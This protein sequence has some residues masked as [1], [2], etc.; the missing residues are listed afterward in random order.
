MSGCQLYDSE[1]FQYRG[2]VL[3]PEE[4]DE[5]AVESLPGPD[6]RASAGAISRGSRTIANS[7]A[8]KPV[9]QAV[10]QDIGLSMERNEDDKEDQDSDAISEPMN[11]LDLRVTVAHLRPLSLPRFR[12]TRCQ[13][14]SVSREKS[15]T[16][17]LITVRPLMGAR[18]WDSRTN[19]RKMCFGN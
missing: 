4:H 9:A 14:S 10:D 7:I 5:A 19:G 8:V 2:R 17:A 3:T 13:Q 16:V 6:R 11:H 12:T 1:P 18:Q 15:R